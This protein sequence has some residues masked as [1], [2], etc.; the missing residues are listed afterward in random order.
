MISIPLATHNKNVVLPNVLQS[1]ARQEI[2]FEVCI[3]DDCSKED[4]QPIVSKFLP[5]AKYKRLEKNVGCRESSGILLDMMNPATEI[6]VLM[7]SDVMPLQKNAIEEL[8][9]N[10]E[11]GVFT[12]AEVKDIR[13]GRTEHENL[14]VF[15]AHVLKHWNRFRGKIICGSRRKKG[16]K[17][18]FSRPLPKK[19]TVTSIGPQKSSTT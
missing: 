8:C 16:L 11:P 4:P 14:D 6:V 10:V 19:S 3:V 18:I 17:M 2:A 12:M 7:S 5:N 9:K 13:V 15:E 1:L